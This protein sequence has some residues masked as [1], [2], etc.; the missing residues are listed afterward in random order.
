MKFIFD[1][2][3]RNGGRER[4]GLNR[5]RALLSFPPR[6]RFVFLCNPSEL[7]CMK[8]NNLI[9]LHKICTSTSPRVKG[10]ETSLSPRFVINNSSV[11]VDCLRVGKPRS[12]GKM[13][14][15]RFKQFSMINLLTWSSA[16]WLGWLNHIRMDS[17]MPYLWFI[18]HNN[19]N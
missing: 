9:K 5:H 13:F 18:S 17:H 19:Q 11:C 16:R 1:V 14:F 15:D 8:Q 3:M 6:S 10:G 4:S 2:H 7:G 12:G